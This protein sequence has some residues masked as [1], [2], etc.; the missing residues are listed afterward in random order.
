[1]KKRITPMASAT[2]APIAIPAIFP[3]ERAGADS[4]TGRIGGGV[5]EAEEEDVDD[6]L[7]IILESVVVEGELENDDNVDE[8]EVVKRDVAELVDLVIGTVVEVIKV[9]LRVCDRKEEVF[10]LE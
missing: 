2:E 3:F 9:E 4:A 8:R 6:L 7:V 1:M 10:V 5:A